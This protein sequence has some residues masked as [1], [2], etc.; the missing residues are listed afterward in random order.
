MS[1]VL[2]IQELIK[3][4]EERR[5]LKD[6]LRNLEAKFEETVKFQED[7][8]LHEL[9]EAKDFESFKQN[10]TE[11]M[12]QTQYKAKE[13]ED[14]YKSEKIQSAILAEATKHNAY[15]P[16]QVANI[17]S[18]EV[19][20]DDTMQPTFKDGRTLSEGI[21]EFL[22]QHENRNLLKPSPSIGGGGSISGEITGDP[23]SDLEIARSKALKT[24]APHDIA[25]YQKLKREMNRR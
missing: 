25:N 21:F 24:G 10:L 1:N 22:S 16:A 2:E 5:R 19:T 9:A 3:V 8:R 23:E 20:V 17:I 11:K 14:R 4:V 12:K 13:W 6:R 18:N 7:K 15:N